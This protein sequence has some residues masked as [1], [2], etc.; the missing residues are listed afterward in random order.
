[1]NK[2]NKILERII[3]INNLV[4]KSNPNKLILKL[5]ISNFY[6]LATDEHIKK[7]MNRIFYKE[8]LPYLYDKKEIELV[9]NPKNGII[10]REV[11]SAY[12]SNMVLEGVDKQITDFCKRFRVNYSRH[13]DDIFL[14]GINIKNLKIAEEYLVFLL[15]KENFEINK[16]DIK[17]V[18]CDQ[19]V[20][21]L[22]KRFKTRSISRKERKKLKIIFH[23]YLKSV[24]ESKIPNRKV[25]K[26]DS[27]NVIKNYINYIQSTDLGYYIS[28]RKYISSIIKRFQI[29][30]CANIKILCEVLALWLLI[31]FWKY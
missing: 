12:F 15:G 21:S 28:I 7:S 17:I 4:N 3:V 20:L 31:K 11:T 30:N 19:S 23:N 27:I 29:R 16:A 5:N 22:M 18:S 14:T 6:S 8:T 9:N 24:Y 25:Y 1:M 13:M 2:I 10:T 26:T